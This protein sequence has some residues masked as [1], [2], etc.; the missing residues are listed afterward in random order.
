MMDVKCTPH[1]GLPLIWHLPQ[2]WLSIGDVS[3][4]HWK[5]G[6]WWFCFKSVKGSSTECIKLSSVVEDF[7]RNQRWQARVHTTAHRY[8]NGIEMHLPHLFPSPSVLVCTTCASDSVNFD[9]KIHKLLK[10]QIPQIMHIIF[11][12]HHNINNK[13][14]DCNV[15]KSEAQNSSCILAKM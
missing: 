6:L 10:R 3:T 12:R 14:T 7:V 1:I 4:F 11:K 2:L 8:V 9:T 5:F 15:V 13:N